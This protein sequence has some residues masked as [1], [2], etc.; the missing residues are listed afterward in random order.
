MDYS[1]FPKMQPGVPTPS[2][3]ASAWNGAM[4]AAAWHRRTIVHGQKSEVKP[5]PYGRCSCVL[6]K[7]TTGSHL[8][9]GSVLAIAAAVYDPTSSTQREFYRSEPIFLGAAPTMIMSY[10]ERNDIGYFAILQEPISSGSI[11]WAA[12]DG[13]VSCTI[14]MQYQSHRFADI[15]E[16]ET[17]KLKSYEYGGAEIINVEDQGEDPGD[18]TAGD[19]L[20][21]VRLGQFH[22]PII[23]I[24]WVGAFGPA[25]TKTCYTNG[26]GV[27]AADPTTDP[28]ARTLTV[29]NAL[30]AYSDSIT[31]TFPEFG[32]AQFNRESAVFDLLA[33]PIRP[34]P[35]GV[36]QTGAYTNF[37]I[38]DGHVTAAS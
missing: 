38:V 19:K 24:T 28:D 10:P 16:T 15:S 36:T 33:M 37:T 1:E 7:N 5:P 21:L 23:P 4:D 14:N 29:A 13:I 18:W 11:G 22:N 2:I 34:E 17:G 32:L 9:T 12:I 6:V 27:T 3:P 26:Q 8:T 31:L 35:T 25:S 20:A 30:G